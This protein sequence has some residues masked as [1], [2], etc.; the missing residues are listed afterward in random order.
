MTAFEELS[1]ARVDF[2]RIDRILCSE[3]RPS[4]MAAA[5]STKL[6]CALGDALT[7]VKSAICC[8]IDTDIEALQLFNSR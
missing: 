7:V 5:D 1:D 2:A 6:V 4:S 3:I 8:D